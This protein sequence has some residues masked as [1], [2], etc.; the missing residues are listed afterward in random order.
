M[1]S[2]P[3]TVETVVTLFGGDSTPFFCDS[4]WSTLCPIIGPTCQRCS[5]PFPSR[6]SLLHS[7]LH[8]CANC[9]LRPPAFTRA[10]TFY[11]YKSPLKEAIWLFKYQGKVSLAGP[12][13]TLL[14]KALTPLPRIDVILPVPLHPTRLRER[15]YNQSLLLACPLSTHLGLPISYTTLVRIRPTK[16][17]TSLRRKDRINNL[18]RSFVVTQPSALLKK[19]SS[20]STMCS[21]Q[22]PPSM[23]APKHFEKPASAMSILSRWREWCSLDEA[24][25]SLRFQVKKETE[26]IYADL[27]I[28]VP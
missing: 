1:P 14:L 19:R 10:W 13:A 9:R 16:P 25:S 2:F 15:E 11:P 22:V 23:N 18:Q 28:S 20:L 7:P 12:L 17:Q 6:I 26:F 27:R 24:V 21:R 4:C 3:T 5:L 8:Q